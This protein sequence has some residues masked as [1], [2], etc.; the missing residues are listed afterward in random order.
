MMSWERLPPPPTVKTS[1]LAEAACRSAP[2][3]P[4]RVITLAGLLTCGSTIWRTFP[5]V[6]SG[7]PAVTRRLQLRG[8]SRNWARTRT[9]FP[10]HPDANPEPKA[11]PAYRLGPRCQAHNRHLPSRLRQRLTWPCGPAHGPPEHWH[12]HGPDHARP[13]VSSRSPYACAPPAP[14]SAPTNA[15]PAAHRSFQSTES[16]RPAP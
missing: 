10:F 1:P 14:R 4:E 15:P 9:A 12:D 8:Q 11:P 7:I 2:R 3:A 13:S 16:K 6:P 5:G